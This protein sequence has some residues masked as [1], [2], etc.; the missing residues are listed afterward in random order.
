VLI[1]APTR[2]LAAQCHAMGT[3][4]ARFVDPPVEFCLITGGTKNLRPQEAELRRRPDVVVCT[5]GRMLDHVRNS[6]V[7]LPA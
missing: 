1:V 3:A 5:P 7:R 4:L 6:Q 2:E